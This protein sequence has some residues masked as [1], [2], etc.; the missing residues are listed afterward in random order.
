MVPVCVG[1]WMGCRWGG[2]GTDEVAARGRRACRRAALVRCH[3]V[4]RG[5][6]SVATARE[7][8]GLPRTA[9]TFILF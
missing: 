2:G 1:M 4:A 6:C 9:A 3:L 5:F 7:Y 8:C